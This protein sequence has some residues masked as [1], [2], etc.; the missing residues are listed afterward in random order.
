MI[1]VPAP[2]DVRILD[3][4]YDAW[5]EHGA[6]ISRLQFP[7]LRHEAPYRSPLSAAPSERRTTS[8]LGRN[9]KGL[10]QREEER[11]G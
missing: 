7:A 8:W 3:R 2:G 4:M 5:C 9:Q 6:N 1:N 11:D 10:G